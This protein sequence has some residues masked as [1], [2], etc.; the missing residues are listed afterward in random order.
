V[1]GVKLFVWDLHGTLEY[2]N[3]H[4]VIDI[5]NAV[6]TCHGYREQFSYEDGQ[7]L[8]GLKWYE[9]FTWLLGEGAYQQAMELQDACFKLSETECE[10]QR[11][12][13]QPTPHVLDVLAAIGR[14]HDQILIS[15]TRT[16]TLELFLDVL[17]LKNF[18]PPGSAF[19]VDQHTRAAVR[20][21]VDVLRE[22]L[23]ARREYEQLVIVGD[24]PS[25]MRL[26][27]VSGGVACLFAHPEFQFRE[28]PADRRIRDLRDLLELV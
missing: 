15:N 21:K 7:K 5:S 4:A 14:R 10:M 12:W 13:M 17:G 20:T 28:C 2:G 19:A 24:S 16:N 23:G 22:F 6:L 3:H 27:E 26:K 25:D 18:F 8:Y 11:R 9:Y 1:S